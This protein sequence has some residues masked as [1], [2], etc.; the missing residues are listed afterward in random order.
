MNSN[1]INEAVDI[2]KLAI[3]ADNAGELDKAYQ[4]Y[5]R[6]LDRFVLGLKYEQNPTAKKMVQEKVMG[7]MERAEE[8]KKALADAKAAPKE[9]GGGGGAKTLNKD[10]KKD[11]EEDEKAKMRGALSSAIVSEKPN[12]KWEDVAGLEGESPYIPDALLR[13]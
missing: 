1:F 3:E 10:D 7:Y 8:I 5:Q 13:F 6:A 9:G 4:L 11:K 12:V 2:V